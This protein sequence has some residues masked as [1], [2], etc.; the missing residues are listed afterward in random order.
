[1]T[2]RAFL[3]T[4]TLISASSVKRESAATDHRTETAEEVLLDEEAWSASKS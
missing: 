3:D 4:N 1:M 2:G